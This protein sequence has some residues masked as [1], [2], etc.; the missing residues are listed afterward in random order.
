MSTHSSAI[1]FT[2]RFQ[3]NAGGAW[4]HARYKQFDNAPVYV[5]CVDV[6]PNPFDPVAGCSIA[7]FLIPDGTVLT[8]A[9]MQR[10][11]EF[12][13]NIGARYDVPV[14]G[15]NLAL[16]GNLYY[17]SS[18]FFGPSGIQFRQD[19]YEVLSLRAE[20]TDPSDRY[21]IALWG[22]NVTDSRY[23]TQVQFN[24]PGIGANW[25]KPVTYGVELGVKL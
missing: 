14:G 13:G 11:P 12:T 2:D 3:I 21:S 18:F 22:E 4:V 23:Q 15:G 20:W 16:S 5:P 7:T 6:L 1:A 24:Q 19:G 25:S 8:D 17:S 10:A 9:T